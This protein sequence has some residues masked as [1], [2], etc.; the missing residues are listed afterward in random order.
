MRLADL[1]APRLDRR[2]GGRDLLARAMPVLKVRAKDLNELAQGAVSLFAQRPLALDEKAESLLTDDA[3]AL[4]AQITRLSRKATGTSNRWKPAQGDGR[5][6]GAGAGK[7]AQPPRASLTGQ[8][9]SPGIF[10]VLVL[11][12]REE[13]LARIADRQAASRQGI[14]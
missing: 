13:S 6:L 10:D 8:G 9:T 7:L 2:A 14:C 3:R 5:G 12:G 1:V 4:L 11:L